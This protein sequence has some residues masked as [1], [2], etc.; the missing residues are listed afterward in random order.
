[1]RTVPF[2]TCLQCQFGF[3]LSGWNLAT[4]GDRGRVLTRY[5]SNANIDTDG[6]V[7]VIRGVRYVSSQTMLAAHDPQFSPAC[8]LRAM[9]SLLMGGLPVAACAIAINTAPLMRATRSLT[10]TATGRVMAKHTAE[11]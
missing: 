2:C 4:F 11:E 3:A 1:M 5:R 8:R 7:R 10:G 6:R 9:S